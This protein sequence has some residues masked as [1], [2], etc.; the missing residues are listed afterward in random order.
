M[1][2]K[3]RSIDD[4]LFESLS[5]GKMRTVTGGLMAPTNTLP[6]ATVSYDKST[7]LKDSSTDDNGNPNDPDN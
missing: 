2:Q 5:D 3:L 1:K 7:G 6:T 4:K